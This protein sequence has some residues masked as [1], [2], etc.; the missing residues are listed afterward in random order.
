MITL[1][2]FRLDPRSRYIIY[3]Q[4]VLLL[5]LLW[6]TTSFMDAACTT[7]AFY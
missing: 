5:S 4:F 6:S 1:T 2:A 3:D 7:R